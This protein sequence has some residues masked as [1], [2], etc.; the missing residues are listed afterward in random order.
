MIDFIRYKKYSSFEHFIILYDT[1]DKTYCIHSK[2]E[3]NS[4]AM[5]TGFATASQ[6]IEFANDRVVAIEKPSTA[7]SIKEVKND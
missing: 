5:I 6:C 7:T 2:D 1:I 4:T 3:E